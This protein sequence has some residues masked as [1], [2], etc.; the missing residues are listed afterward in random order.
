M[1]KQGVM[2]ILPILFSY[3]FPDSGKDLHV[4]GLLYVEIIGLLLT[5]FTTSPTA[6]TVK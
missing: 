1:R 4:R 2:H 5:V 3:K 6:V